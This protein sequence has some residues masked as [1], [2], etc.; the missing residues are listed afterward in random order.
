QHL[1][2][3]ELELV[4]TLRAPASVEHDF[5]LGMNYRMKRIIWSYLVDVPPVEH[6]G[7]VF[8][9][10]AMK[11]GPR[12]TLVA[13]GRLDYVP[14][15]ARVIPSPRGAFIFKPTPQQAVRISGST[16]FRSPTFLEAYLSLPI[17]LAP[18]GAEL[19][20]E[21]A[22]P[23]RAGFQLNPEQIVTAEA[24]YL[25]QESEYFNAEITAY[26]N[27]VT[28]FIVLADRR[29]ASLSNRQ[30]GLGGLNPETGRYTV[31]FGGWDNQCDTYNVI[32][33]EVGGRVFPLDGVDLFA[34]YALNISNQ[35]RT[36]GC[37]VPE[38]RRTSRH[39]INAG[40]QVRTKAGIDGELMFHYQSGQQW[41]EQIVTPTG[42]FPQVFDLP[43]YTL[44]NARVGFRFLDDHAE[45]SAT[46]FNALA[47]I[48]SDEPPQMHPFG[49][50]VGRRVMGF[51]T[52][53][54]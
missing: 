13:S 3:A 22:A 51:F 31:G 32:G 54:L 49:N 24:S 17:Q 37:L 41:V 48:T 34:N 6:H 42:I 39:K 18:P 29:I 38:D 8:L 2:N 19:L 40:V 11:F 50:R 9:Q 21:S 20:S 15:L 14:F 46:V 5:H 7:A 43:A 45:V 25:N 1:L 28:D 36:E 16:A 35:A 12:F 33:G 52:Y 47:G 10:D 53:N 30:D 26:Y 27:R 23:D 44:L 4:R